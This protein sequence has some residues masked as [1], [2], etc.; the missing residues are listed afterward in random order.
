LQFISVQNT[1]GELPGPTLIGSTYILCSRIF[2]VFPT[3]VG[4]GAFVVIDTEQGHAASAAAAAVQ[5]L[6]L[7]LVPFGT[8]GQ[9]KKLM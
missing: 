3:V 1:R 7:Q 5:L 6:L 2:T 9:T 8:I 4:A